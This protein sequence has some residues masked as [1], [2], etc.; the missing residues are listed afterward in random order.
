MRWN[1]LVGAVVGCLA[2]RLAP[3]ET[4]AFFAGVDPSM[5]VELERAGGVYRDE[6]GR[7]ADAIRVLRDHGCN[8]FR[9]RV[10]VRPSGDFNKVWGATQ[11]LEQA[12]ALGRRAK[13][14]GAQLLLDLH[15]SDTWADPKK[16]G[17]PAE[18]AGLDAKGLEGK[19]H[20][21]TAAVLK[22][23]TDAGARPDMVQVG[24]EV[25]NGMLWPAGRTSEGTAE[26]REGRWA[27]FSALL[28][29]GARAV[30]EASS[31]ERPIGVMIHIDGGGRPGRAKWFFSALAK[32]PVDFDVVG[33]SFYPA[34]GDSMEGLR[35]NLRDLA[36]GFGKDVVVAETSYPWMAME[37]DAKA[38]AAMTWPMTREGQVAFLRDLSVALREAPKGRG[39]G[40]VWW[41]PEAVPVKGRF[42]WRKGAEALFDL[43]G[44]PLPAMGELGK[45]AGE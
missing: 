37:V 6:G 26:E 3:G 39:R 19:V 21:Y 2:G 12:K 44:R 45:A 16:Q 29:S 28:N 4:P 42:V 5:L 17:I 33:L 24:N 38:R 36:E 8:L 27:E 10:F 1:L 22:E 32:H 13:E 20:D 7:S 9:V 23:M 11:D 41:Y 25:T 34:W 18:W 35:G 30:R 40:Y 14:S 15:Y 43:E 31:M